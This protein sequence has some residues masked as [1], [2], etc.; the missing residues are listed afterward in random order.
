M[1]NTRL[2]KE[3]CSTC[4]V[5]IKCLQLANSTQEAFGIWGGLTPK[6]RGF[7]R[8]TRPY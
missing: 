6:E 7:R 1:E 4:K 8:M 5:R 2:A 3:I